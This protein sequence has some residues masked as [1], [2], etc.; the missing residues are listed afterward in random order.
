MSSERP[1]LLGDQISARKYVEAGIRGQTETGLRM[2]RGR[3]NTTTP[4]ILTGLGFTVTRAGVGDITVSFTPAFTT[5]PSAVAS[6]EATN[7][8]R[9]VTTDGP[10]TSAIRFIRWR[11]GT[12]DPPVGGGVTNEDGIL[13]FVIVGPIHQ[14]T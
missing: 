8:G 6:A 1:L 10:T 7:I 13:D 9:S 2:L 14:Q 5:I 3:I 11:I 4:T 12:G